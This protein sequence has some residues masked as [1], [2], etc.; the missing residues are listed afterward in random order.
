VLSSLLSDRPGA[1]CFTDPIGDGTTE[2]PRA[3]PYDFDSFE[4]D[5]DNDG[6]PDARDAT[7]TSP[8][9]STDSS[10]DGDTR[11]EAFDSNPTSYSDQP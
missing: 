2:Q 1:A 5:R 7:P 8:Y 11:P 9:D 4:R 3:T 10:Q 6:K